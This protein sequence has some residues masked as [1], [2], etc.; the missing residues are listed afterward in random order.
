MNRI[1]EPVIDSRQMNSGIFGQSQWSTGFNDDRDRTK[2]NSELDIWVHW[3]TGSDSSSS[4]AIKFSFTRRRGA[5][6]VQ[7]S[8]HMSLLK[9]GK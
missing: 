4:V 5:Q 3:Q 9:R 7:L 2:Q 1:V 6:S 8:L